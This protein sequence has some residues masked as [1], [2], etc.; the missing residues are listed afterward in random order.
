MLP[1]WKKLYDWGTG[2]ADTRGSRIGLCSLT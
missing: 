2:H 1:R